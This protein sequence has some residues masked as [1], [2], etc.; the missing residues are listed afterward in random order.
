MYVTTKGPCIFKKCE[1]CKTVFIK[2]PVFIRHG[3]G[4]LQRVDLKYFIY[5]RNSMDI[6]HLKIIFKTY[7]T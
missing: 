4:A 2:I 6:A 7:M 5:K 1:L 3:P